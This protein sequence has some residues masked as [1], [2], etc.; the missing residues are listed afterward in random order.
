MTPTEFALYW[1]PR[2]DS[3]AAEAIAQLIDSTAADGGTLG[4]NAPMTPEVKALLIVQLARQVADGDLHVLLG[5]APGGPVFLVMLRPNRMPNCRHTAE[6]AK[7]VVHPDW[8]GR[9]LVELAFQALVTRADALG[10]EQ[11][12]LD[13]RE[14]SRAHALWQRFGFVSYG[15]LDDYARVDGVQYR[16]HFMH[17]PVAALRQRLNTAKKNSSIPPAKDDNHVA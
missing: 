5:R 3:D 1:N 9:G 15:V 11:F 2:L 13:V 14:G 16:G 10:I 8:R 4:Y 7:G 12:V 6:L 17:Q